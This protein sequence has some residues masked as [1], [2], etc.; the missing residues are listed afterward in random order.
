MT[1][2]YKRKRMRTPLKVILRRFSRTLFLLLIIGLIPFFLWFLMENQNSAL[3]RFNGLVEAE[4]ENVGPIETARILS[5]DVQAGQ[6]VSIGDVL[7]RLDSADRAMDLAMNE[8]RLKDYEQSVL[9]YEQGIERHRQNLQ[10]SERRCRQAVRE[11][12]VALEAEKMNRARETAELAGTKAEIAR[13]QPL[14]DKH[15]ISETELS[16]LRPAADALEQSVAQYGPLIEA[17]EKQHALALADLEEVKALL[18]ATAKDGTPTDP[19]LTAMRQ[20]AEA[21]RQAA[22]KDPTVLRATRSGI[23][24]RVMR[25]SGDVALAGEPVVRITTSGTLNITGMLMQRQLAGLAVGDTLKVSRVVTN[26]PTPLTAQVE[27]I[28]PEVMDLFDPLNPVPRFPIR[29]CRVRLRVLD[30][31]DGLVPGETVILESP[32]RES[33]LDGVKRICMLDTLIK[34]R[35][36]KF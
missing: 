18:A 1:Q 27:T 16:R 26:D 11:A 12:A 8:A 5:V 21:C 7:V 34:T 30:G 13:L 28:E 14:V 6:H 33:W 36:P 15:L 25:Q 32:R 20:A 24:S 19:I 29:G 4:S 2:T 23:V 9:R 35:D 3:Y 31:H 10:D 17:L 22:V